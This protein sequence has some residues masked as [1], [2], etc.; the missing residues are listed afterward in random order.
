MNGRGREIFKAVQA[1]ERL[2]WSPVNKVADK[3]ELSS[4]AGCLRF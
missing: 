4:A 1:M 2:R 3:G